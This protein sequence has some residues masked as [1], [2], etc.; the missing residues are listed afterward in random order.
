MIVTG[1]SGCRSVTV[2]LYRQSQHL[3]QH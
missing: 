3:Q 1:I 2:H